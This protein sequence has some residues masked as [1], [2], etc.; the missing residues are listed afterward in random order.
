MLSVVTK[1][2]LKSPIPLAR[3]KCDLSAR[4]LPAVGVLKSTVNHSV[5]GT[6][7]VAVR[8]SA[9]LHHPQGEDA[10]GVPPA[11]RAQDRRAGHV[12][13]VRQGRLQSALDLHASS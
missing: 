3:S 9:V 7:A 6:V 2:L 5:V 11:R 10:D 12:P 4:K 8:L 1:L 13:S